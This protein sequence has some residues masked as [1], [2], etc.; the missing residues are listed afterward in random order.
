MKPMRMRRVGHEGKGKFSQN[1]LREERPF[2]RPVCQWE[3]N[4]KMD[5]EEMGCESMDLI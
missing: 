3:D 4:N 2:G 1:T 5:F